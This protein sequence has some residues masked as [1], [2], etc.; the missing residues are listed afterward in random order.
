MSQIYNGMPAFALCDLSWHKSRYSNPD[1]SCLE[2]ARLADGVIAIRNSRYP[3]GPAL[4]YTEAEIG[5]FLKGAKEGEF[6]YL[7]PSIP[8]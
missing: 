1:G 2:V 3:Y 7:T 8:S 6:D 4:I 5:A